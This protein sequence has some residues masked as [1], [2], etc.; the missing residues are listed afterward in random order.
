MNGLIL[1]GGHSRRMGQPKSLL[2]YHGKPQYQHLKDLLS[3]F[4][5]RVFLSC[6]E[7]QKDLFEGCETIFDSAQF[8]DIGPMNGV[9]SA[10][11]R[12]KTNAWLV[13][14]CDYPLLEK[15]DL[16]QLI[17]ERDTNCI[18]TVF[19]NPETR[20][21]EP[22]HCIY[23]PEAGPLLLQWVQLGNESMRR[24]LEQAL[25]QK[26]IPRH[27]ECLKSVD[28]M[29]EFLHIIELK[30]GWNTDDTDETRI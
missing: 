12:D 14:G 8:G 9:L 4:C 22:L 24:F 21:P 6:R 26:V 27:P 5:D 10:F 17:H 30:R 28:T 7:E 16:E 19:V 23:E 11:E 15:S 18:A 25:V 1:A 20:F 3:G 2:N 29:E 13:L